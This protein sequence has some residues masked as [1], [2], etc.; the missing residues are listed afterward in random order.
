MINDLVAELRERFSSVSLANDLSNLSSGAI[1]FVA[2]VDFEFANLTFSNQTA[3]AVIAVHFLDA[4]QRK[5]SVVTGEGEKRGSGW[6]QKDD[7]LASFIAR[8][9]ALKALVTKLPQTISP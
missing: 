2:V 5:V 6:G 7:Y 3:K 8:D 4:S 1:D 9:A